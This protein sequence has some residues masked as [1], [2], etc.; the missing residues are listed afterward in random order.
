MLSVPVGGPGVGVGVRPAAAAARVS[1]AGRRRRA[2]FPTSAT[3]APEVVPRSLRFPAGTS[4]RW[5]RA[6]CPSS[7]FG[8]LAARG[9]V[10]AKNG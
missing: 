7:I 5:Q 6:A 2:W 4:F 8:D 10:P 3:A 1:R 9:G